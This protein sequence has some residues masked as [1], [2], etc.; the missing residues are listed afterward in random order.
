MPKKLPPLKRG[1]LAQARAR[2]ARVPRVLGAHYDAANDA[3]VVEMKEKSF[4]GVPRSALRGPLA[5]GTA[6][7]LNNIH[8]EGDGTYLFWPDLEDGLDI[9]YVLKRFV[10]ITSA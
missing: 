2:G 10:G 3:I 9:A 5:H 6:E 4:V 7:Q 8:I 1:S